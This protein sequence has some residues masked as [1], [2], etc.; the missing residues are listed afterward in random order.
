M[1]RLRSDDE[2]TDFYLVERADPVAARATVLELVAE[3]IPERFGLDSVDDVQV[4]TPMH[5]GELGVTALNSE[6]QDRLN[7][8]GDELDLGARRFRAGDKVMQIR[9]NYDLG[10]FNGDIGRVA[11]AD[12]EEDTLLVEFDNRLVAVPQDSL[13]ELTPA[14]ACTIHKAQGSEYPAVVIALH[15]QHWIMLRRN[16]LYTAVTRGRRLVVVVGTTRAVAQAVRNASQRERHTL[17]SHRLRNPA[18]ATPPV[19]VPV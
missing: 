7:A 17:L 11:A 1:P 6:L 9:N 13:D 18:A 15:D 19:P 16:L 14:Y 10:V 5:R 3:R 12:E 4:L 2:L 8:S